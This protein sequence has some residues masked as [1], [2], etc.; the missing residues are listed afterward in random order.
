MRLK[1][2]VAVAAKSNISF[3]LNCHNGKGSTSWVNDIRADDDYVVEDPRGSTS[4]RQQR[5][6]HNRLDIT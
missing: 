2:S 3:C 6:T 4:H 5:I 1:T